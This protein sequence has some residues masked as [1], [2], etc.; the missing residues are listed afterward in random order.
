[1]SRSPW[2]RPRD[3][4][5]AGVIVLALAVA[6]VLAWVSSD[7]AATNAETASAPGTPL[8]IPQ[9]PPEQLTE[10][11]RA[12]SAQTPVPV[13]DG[14]TVVTGNAGTVTGH[15]AQT[16]QRRWFY[17]RDL[18]LC[19]VGQAWSSAIAAYRTEAGCSQVTRLEL[20]TGKRA[21]QRNGDA[22]AGTR[23][24]SDGTHVVV[25][26]KHLINVWSSDLI[27][28]MEYGRLPAPVEPE[29]Q[30]RP[31]C[32]PTSTDGETT[33][34]DQPRC[35]TPLGEQPREGCV[36][37]SIALSQGKIAVVERC[38][39]DAADWLTVIGTTHDKDGENKSDEPNVLLSAELPGKDARVVAVA[40]S[41]RPQVAVVL[42]H[43]RQLLVYGGPK[44]KLIQQYALEQPTAELVAA[45]PGRTPVLTRG[46][47]TLFWFTGSATLALDQQ[48][49][50]PLWTLPDT[51]GPGLAWGSSTLMPIADGLAVID[52]KTGKSQRTIAVDRD[53]YDGLVRL[54]YVGPVLLE[55]RGPTLIALR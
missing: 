35:V 52:E 50:R 25:T 27:R 43:T 39:G 14:S 22:E 41:K 18:P 13:A 34:P 1:M 26:G 33:T 3:R 17:Q 37:S 10:R 30:H 49:L 5:I 32:A 2:T 44:G 16:G 36:F 11:W 24:L 46:L 20:D 45:Q 4:V 6:G 15:D 51:R 48:T 38:R 7:S 21:A 55:Q 53:G 47:S 40:G 54:G 9:T 28:A 23:L 12:P 19:T 42:P 31:G 8:R 29:R